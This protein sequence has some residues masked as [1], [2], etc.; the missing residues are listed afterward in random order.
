MSSPLPGD[1]VSWGQGMSLKHP[2]TQLIFPFRKSQCRVLQLVNPASPATR[3]LSV[4]LV[5]NEKKTCWSGS[6]LVS[7]HVSGCGLD[8]VSP[9]TKGRYPNV[10]QSYTT[11]QDR[12]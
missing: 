10:T 1:Y 6:G 4:V 7:D 11:S 12:S 5:K 8:G 3:I 2:G 9:Y